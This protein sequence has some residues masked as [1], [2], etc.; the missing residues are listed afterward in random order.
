MAAGNGDDEGNPLP[1]SQQSPANAPN[2]LTIS[3]VD[4]S[5]NTASFANYGAGVDIFAPGVSVKSSYI[6][7]NTATASLSGTSMA[8]PHVVGLALY[9]KALE[10]LASPAAITSRI[11]AL[12]TSDKITGTLSGSPNLLAYNGNA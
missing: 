4:S 11:K 3:A 10:G 5:W 6:G 12:G 8:T 9:L 2:A 1:V 7:T